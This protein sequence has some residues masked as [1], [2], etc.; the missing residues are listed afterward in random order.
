LENGDVERT[1]RDHSIAYGN[2]NEIRFLVVTLALKPEN[3]E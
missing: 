3:T 2:Y 1:K